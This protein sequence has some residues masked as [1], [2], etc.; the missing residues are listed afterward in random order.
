MP[1][2]S[3]LILNIYGQRQWSTIVTTVYST[4]EDYTPVPPVDALATVVA[5]PGF[6]D[7]HRQTSHEGDGS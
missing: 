1:R 3:T 5:G 6:H 2:V 7:H 4:V